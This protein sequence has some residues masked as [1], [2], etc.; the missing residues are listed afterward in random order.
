MKTSITLCGGKIIDD[1]QNRYCEICGK[2]LHHSVTC[3]KAEG[4]VCQKHC[5]RCRHYMEKFQHCTYRD[6]LSGNNLTDRVEGSGT[7][8]KSQQGK[9]LANE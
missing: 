2:E 4:L 5:L 9:L 8:E 1:Y 6:K 3:R 7:K